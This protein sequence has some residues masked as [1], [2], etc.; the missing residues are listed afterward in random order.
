MTKGINIVT[1]PSEYDVLEIIILLVFYCEY[2]C[3]YV[4]V[5]V[6]GDLFTRIKWFDL[7]W[8]DLKVLFEYSILNLEFSL[9]ELN[10]S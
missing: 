1:F 7:I 6:T 4:N 2:S 3:K 5:P 8:F 10:V 9:L